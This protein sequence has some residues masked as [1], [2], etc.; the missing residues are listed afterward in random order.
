M[1]RR[2]TIK[3]LVGGEHLLINA[4]NLLVDTRLAS[5]FRDDHFPPRIFIS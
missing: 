1:F 2:Y 4:L 5:M 3:L